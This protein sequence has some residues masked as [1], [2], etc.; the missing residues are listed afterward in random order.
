MEQEI[1]KRKLEQKLFKAREILRCHQEAQELVKGRNKYY[2][3]FAADVAWNML[4]GILQLQW[5]INGL[6]NE[7]YDNIQYAET[8]FG[9]IG[10]KRKKNGS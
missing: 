1:K 6:E 2:D 10:K 7:W 3:E 5:R 9:F 8:I 4:T